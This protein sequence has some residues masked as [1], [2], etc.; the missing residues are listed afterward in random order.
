M[1]SVT[2]MIEAVIDMSCPSAEGLPASWTGLADALTD[3][4]VEVRFLRDLVGFQHRPQGWHSHRWG[5]D[6]QMHILYLIED[7]RIDI[8]ALD[9]RHEAGPGEALGVGPGYAGPVSFSPG[10]RFHEVWFGLRREGRPLYATD[11]LLLRRDAWRLRWCFELIA[12]LL[13][14]P[15][16]ADTMTI[17]TAYALLLRLIA[18]PQDDDDAQRQLGPEQRSAILRWTRDHLC[19]GPEPA[20]LAQVVGLS[21]DYFSRCFTA[22]FGC[23]PRLVAGWSTN[24]CVPPPAPCMKTTP[25]WPSSPPAT[26]SSTA[27]ISAACSA[28]PWAAHR[29]NGANARAGPRCRNLQGIAIEHGAVPFL[30]PMS[31]KRPSQA[32]CQSIPYM[33]LT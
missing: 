26:A 33:L 6:Q 11:N 30:D 29:G 16:A 15:V 1:G 20:D 4:T 3:I 18:A 17:R 24:A 12:D 5:R 10:S 27:P 32:T 9:D 28:A 13:L 14:A 2:D 8:G 7:G 23:P 31:P 21:H 25:Q 22:T 19:H